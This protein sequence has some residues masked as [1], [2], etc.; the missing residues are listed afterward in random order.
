MMDRRSFLLST[1]FLAGTLAL[2]TRPAHAGLADA[3]AAALRLVSRLGRLAEDGLDPGHYDIPAP[4]MMSAEPARFQE[5]LHRAA[6]LALEDL[7]LGRGRDLPG[8][9]DIRRDAAAVGPERWLAELGASLDPAAVIDRAAALPAGTGLLKAEMARL[10]AVAARGGWVAVPAGPTASLDPGSTDPARVPVLRAR[11]AAEDPAL[12]AAP[13]GGALYD[14]P[15]E[16]AVRRFQAAAGLEADGRVGRRTLALLNLPI[17]ARIAQL[18]A[19]LDM[20]RGVA[21][22]TPERRIEVNI[23]DYRLRVEEGGATILSMAV[24]VGRPDRA[25]P[26]MRTRMVAAQ[27]NP[28]WGVPERN[29]RED[30]LPRFRR[31]PQAMIEKGFRVFGTVEGQRVE[32]DPRTI[33]W[34]RVNPQ[35]F[36]YVVRQDAGDANALGRIKLVMPNPDA[37]FMHDTPERTLFRRADRAHSSGCIRLEQPMEL[38]AVL[39]DGTPGWDV[40]RAQATLDARTTV[41]VPLRRPLPV[42]LHYS[43]V[44]VEEGR[45]RIRPDIYGLDEAYARAI[46]AATRPVVMAARG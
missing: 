16:E 19:A 5:G 39:L 26:V 42:R 12:A 11:L 43:T 1:G 2:G 18:R 6:A 10:K 14:R 34:S 31:D 17:E 33:D 45:L 35:R 9:P 27:F 22:A 15:L 46:A 36:P 41:S 23:P 3:Q 38:L 30:L 32:I 7:L 21:A 20:R 37:I 4:A 24:V 44:T 40:A 28:P 25:T 8:R 29:A 13:D